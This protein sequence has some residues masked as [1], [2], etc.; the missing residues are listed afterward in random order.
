MC[1]AIQ[2]MYDDGVKDKQRIILKHILEV[3]LKQIPRKQSR[4][5]RKR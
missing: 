4:M 5:R 2:E 3:R 1:K